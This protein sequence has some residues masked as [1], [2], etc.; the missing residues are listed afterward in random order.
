MHA[1][2]RTK[3]GFRE[4]GKDG[5]PL[6]LQGLMFRWGLDFARPLPLTDRGNIYVLVY[7][8]HYT[9]WMELVALPSKS[10]SDVTFL[11][12]IWFCTS[13][14][15]ALGVILRIRVHNYVWNSTHC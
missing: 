15:G 12:K 1:C 3:A 2:A 9:K 6:V 13:G 7:I 10:S 4:M 8:E 14:F 11:E 5:Q